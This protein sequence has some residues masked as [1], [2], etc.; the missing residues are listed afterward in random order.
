MRTRLCH[1]VLAAILGTTSVTANADVFTF[2]TVSQFNMRVNG[3]NGPSRITGVLR[4]TTTPTTLEYASLASQ[5]IP[6]LLTMTEKPGR[7]Y[8]TVELIT[9]YP[10]PNMVDCGLELRN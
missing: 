7:Y 6:L 2:D 4:N 9:G 5:C 8:L 10:L 1:A 3:G